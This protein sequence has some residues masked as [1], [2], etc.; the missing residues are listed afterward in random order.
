MLLKTLDFLKQ[1]I[2][3]YDHNQIF[4]NQLKNQVLIDFQ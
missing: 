3:T 1:P 4:C 2:F